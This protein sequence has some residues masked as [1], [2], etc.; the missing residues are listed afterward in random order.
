MLFLLTAPARK[1]VVC[2]GFGDPC[3]HMKH[4]VAVTFPGMGFARCFAAFG[5][6]RQMCLH[7][8]CSGATERLNLTRASEKL[9]HVFFCPMLSPNSFWCF[10]HLTRA[11]WRLE[12]TFWGVKIL[13]VSNQKFFC[14][15]P[16]HYRALL[17]FFRSERLPEKLVLLAVAFAM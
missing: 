8:C 17:D 10:L 7:S 13:Y 2:S 12:A 4:H 15:Q 14:D 1:R 6:L 16:L 3:H 5:R 9:N 11:P